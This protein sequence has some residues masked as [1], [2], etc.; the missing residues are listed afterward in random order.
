[1]KGKTVTRKELAL[2][3]IPVVGP[4]GEVHLEGSWSREKRHIEVTTAA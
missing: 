3:W 2:H 4:D 1:M